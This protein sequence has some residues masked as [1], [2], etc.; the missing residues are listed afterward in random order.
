MHIAGLALGKLI[1]A[2][3]N[4]GNLE[5]PELTLPDRSVIGLGFENPAGQEK[6]LGQLL[7]P[8]LAQ[9][10]GSNDQGPASMVLPR[11]TSSARRAPLDSGELNANSAAST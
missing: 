6:F 10:R 7:K 5:R 8:L 2:N 1:R 9:V 11:P 4:L 3:D